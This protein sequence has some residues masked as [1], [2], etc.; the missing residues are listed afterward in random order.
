[1][2]AESV[3]HKTDVGGVM[4][5]I[6]NETELTAAFEKMTSKFEKLKIENYQFLVQQMIKGGRETI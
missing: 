6:R 2:L 4:V 3:S 5:D 1:M